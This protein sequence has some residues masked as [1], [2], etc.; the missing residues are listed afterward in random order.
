MTNLVKSLEDLQNITKKS[1]IID[2]DIKALLESFN[3]EEL[4]ALSNL[5]FNQIIIFNLFRLFN[6]KT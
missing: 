2:L 1:N 6:Q 4:L 5:M 3:Q